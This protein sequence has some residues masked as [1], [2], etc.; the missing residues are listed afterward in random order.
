MKEFFDIAISRT[1]TQ[2]VKWDMRHTP[3]GHVRR[4]DRFNA[5]D[6]IPMWVADMDFTVAPEIASALR[7]RVA[8]PV[9][10]YT[11]APDSYRAAVCDWMRRRQG[12]APAPRWLCSTHG[13]VQALN[14]CV[15]AFSTP[16]DAIIIPSPVYYPFI[17]AVENNGRKALR[18]SLRETS[19]GTFAL[20]L[21]HIADLAAQE[22]CTCLLL[23]N[24]HNPVGRAWNH[25]D[26]SALASLCAQH[27]VVVVSDEIHADLTLPA[28]RFTP[29]QP[30]AAAAGCQSVICSSASK[31]FNLA[32][33][34]TSEI[35]IPCDSMRLRFQKELACAGVFGAHLFG[36]VATEAAYTC[37]EQWLNG[38]L[39]YLDQS[40]T[41]VRRLL[42]RDTCPLRPVPADATYLVWL[43]CRATTCD[44]A[45]LMERFLESAHVCPEA[46]PLFGPEGKGF[47]RLN[48]ACP[49]AFLK[50][51]LERII[52][53]FT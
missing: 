18:S 32:G 11:H 37:A 13:V 41:V 53:A 9:Y 29:F 2:A 19:D 14:L 46:G 12:W 31:T 17:G 36:P 42:D 5:G 51:A 22:S 40:H 45:A 25:S 30:I 28:H 15:R 20:D 44:D 10:G 35:F 21:D 23:C 8:H 38:L 47:V 50:E 27:G 26:L 6:A 52:K 34:T 43:D 24:P 1:N 7:E 48:I 33:L 39:Q 49:H 16:G 3:D 4:T